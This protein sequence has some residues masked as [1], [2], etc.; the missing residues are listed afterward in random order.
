M[1]RLSGPERIGPRRLCAVALLT[2]P[3]ASTNPGADLVDRDID[4]ALRRAEAGGLICGGLD[5]GRAR[6]DRGADHLSSQVQDIELVRLAR[7]IEQARRDPA[8]R[9]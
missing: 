1:A 5:D 6:A 4:H 8:I 2:P 9:H 3:Q 7:L